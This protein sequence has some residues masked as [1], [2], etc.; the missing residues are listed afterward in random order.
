MQQGFT[1]I[2]MLVVVLIIGILSAIALP[3]YEG[4]VERSHA[5]EA[6]TNGR[7]LVD[8]MNRALAERPDESP[9]SKAALDVKIGGG[10]WNASGTKYATRH[11]EYDISSGTYVLIT[12]KVSGGRYELYMYTG[13]SD[14]RVCKWKGRNA[15]KVCQSLVGF[16]EEAISE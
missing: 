4:A 13:N 16:T 1:L 5:A 9:D 6:V 10:K 2:E 12:H 3:Q 15:Q 7:V 11:F 14:K 8:S